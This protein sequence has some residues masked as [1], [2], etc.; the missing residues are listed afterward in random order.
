MLQINN[1]LD[2]DYFT[3]GRLGVTPFAPSVNGAIGES[4]WNYNSADWLH[5][6]MVAPGAPRA[7]WLGMSYRLDL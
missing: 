7:V 3:A 6:T 4:G 2:K 1:L 5:T